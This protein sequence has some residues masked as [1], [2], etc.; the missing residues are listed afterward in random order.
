M[1]LSAEEK[2]RFLKALEEDQEFRLAVAGLLGLGEV[3]AELKKL[4]EDFSNYVKKSER[5]WRRNEKRWEE[6]N[7][8]FSRLDEMLGAVAESRHS[9]YVWEDLRG[10]KDGGAVVRR[11]RN[12]KVV[13]VDVGLL[14]ETD[15]RVYVV[16]VKV[17]PEIEDVGALLAKSEVVRGALGREAVPILTAT[18][19]G[20][21]VEKYARGKRVLIYS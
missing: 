2:K 8:R 11:V 4:R 13:N 12:A 10:D 1:S 21:D 20:D 14:V 15:R 19:I 18:W 17:K 5:R 16:E 6:A 3:L 9:R 7:K